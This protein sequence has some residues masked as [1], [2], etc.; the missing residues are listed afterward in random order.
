MT[1]TFHPYEACWECSGYARNGTKALMSYLILKFPYASSLGIYNCRDQRGTATLSIHSDGRAGDTKIPMN[2]SAAN[3]TLGDP[4]VK[5]LISYARELGLMGIIYNRVRYDSKTPKGRYY[6]G[7]NPHR[8]HVH[9]E[10]IR[11]Y[12]QS[13]TLDKI[14]KIC[15]NPGGSTPIP[16]PPTPT[17]PTT[18]WTDKIIMALPTVKEGDGMGNRTALAPDV[19]RAQGLLLANGFKDK[20]TTKPESACDGKFGSGTKSA[21]I[22]FQKSVKLTADGIIGQ[23]TWTKLLGE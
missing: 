1:A 7:V 21:T 22:S 20:N 10:Q 6:T 18:D 11:S 3:P 14:I 15:G 2:G 12:A 23:A 16:I 8:D 9:W 17:P 19:K 4:V 13:L 5:F